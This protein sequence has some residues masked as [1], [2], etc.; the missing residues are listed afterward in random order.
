MFKKSKITKSIG[1]LV[2]GIW[3]I[4]SG[5]LQLVD[6]AIPAVDTIMALLALA[7]GVLIILGK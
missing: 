3:L 1:M 6:I 7:A 2:L 4:L 5:L